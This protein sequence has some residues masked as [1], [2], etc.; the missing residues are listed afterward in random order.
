MNEYTVLKAY[1]QHI[2]G[3][4]VLLNARQAKYLLLN[5]SVQLKTKEPTPEPAKKSKEAN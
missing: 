4:T 1:E 5:G 2:I 3:D